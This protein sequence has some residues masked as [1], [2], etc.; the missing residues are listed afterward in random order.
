MLR[1][2]NIGMKMA[3]LVVEHRVAEFG[4]VAHRT[5]RFRLGVI[6]ENMTTQKGLGES[7]ASLVI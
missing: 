3:L 6:A 4:V 7:P 5:I 2:Y 1:E